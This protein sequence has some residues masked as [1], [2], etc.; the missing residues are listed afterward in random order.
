MLKHELLWFLL[1]VC[2]FFLATSSVANETDIE[3]PTLN[4]DATYCFEY[5]WFGPDYD[6]NTIYNGTCDDFKDDTRAG[7]DIPCAS[8]IVISYDGTIPDVTYL[9]NNNK[10]SVLCRKSENQACVTYTYWYKNLITNQTHMCARV[11]TDSSSNNQ[12]PVCYKQ[13][14]G[15]Y[16]V[17]LC[18]CNSGSGLSSMPCN[19]KGIITSKL[20]VEVILIALLLNL[21]GK[22]LF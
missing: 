12:F 15:G 16:E 8:P 11:R 2:A 21:I 4:P 6:N 5:T 18:I 20:T 1:V 17:E 19:S 3:Y 10:A 14:Q 22:V 9:W 13:K 7:D